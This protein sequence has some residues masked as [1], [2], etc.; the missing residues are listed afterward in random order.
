[1]AAGRFSG[2]YIKLAGRD[3]FIFLLKWASYAPRLEGDEDEGEDEIVATR[4][5]PSGSGQ[6]ELRHS[7]VQ[8]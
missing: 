3:T 7:D 4:F 1:M 6:F 5:Q 8:H 2:I